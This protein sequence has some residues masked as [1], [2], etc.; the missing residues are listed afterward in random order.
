MLITGGSTI[1]ISLKEEFA[2][3]SACYKFS[4]FAVLQF[5]ISK[6]AANKYRDQCK[7]EL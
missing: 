7:Y 4:S 5:F 2:S 1:K 6:H 3:D